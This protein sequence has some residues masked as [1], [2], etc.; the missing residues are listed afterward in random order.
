MKFATVIVCS[1]F[2]LAV[3]CKDKGS[4]PVSPQTGTTPTPIV[5]VVP[6]TIVSFANN[7]LP[8]IGNYGCTGCHGGTSGLFVGTVAQLK[9]GGLH[10]PAVVSGSSATSNLALKISATPPFGARMPRG[11]PYMPDSVQLVIRRWIDQ[12]ALDN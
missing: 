5:P 12:G 1:L 8:I 6:D 7:V 10:G 9:Q 4:D 11:G 3:G 2:L